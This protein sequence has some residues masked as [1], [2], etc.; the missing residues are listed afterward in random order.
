MNTTTIIRALA[1]VVALACASIANAQ[2][3]GGAGTSQGAMP[4]GGKLS[5]G[6]NVGAQTRSST[7]NTDFSFPIYGQTAAVTTTTSVDGGPLFDLNV[8]YRIVSVFGIGVGYSAFNRTG[9]AQG[10]ASIPSP[11]FFNRPASVTINPVDAKRT[12]NNVYIVVAG[13]VPIT[14]AVELSVFVGPSFTKV[15]QDVLGGFAVPSG[16]QNVTSGTQTESGTA[17]G[18]NVGADL[19]Y[20][21]TRLVGAGAFIRYNGGSV[22]LATLNDIKVGGL[23]IGIGARLRF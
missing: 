13:Y 2:Q 5:I 9:T 12:E 4:L 15:K 7:N 3:P 17:K 11:V 19:S 14:N 23:Q 10:A 22:D 18:V 8:G 21:F 16:T 6:V 1:T 20:Q